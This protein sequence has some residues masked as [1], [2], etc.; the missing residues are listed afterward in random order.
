MKYGSTLFDLPKRNILISS[1]ISSMVT[2]L[3]ITMLF[4]LLKVFNLDIMKAHL[5]QN[6]VL[7]VM[8]IFIWGITFYISH[9][10]KKEMS[11][12]RASLR[13]HFVLFLLAHTVAL[14]YIVMQVNMS[15]IE[16][17]NWIYLYNMQFIL[18]FVV[19]YAIYIL[20]YNLIGKV[21]LSMILTSCTLVILGIVNYLK[22]I[23]RGD[24]LYPSDFT[25]IMH[26]Q[27][28]I[29]MVMDYFSW[30][31]IFVIILSIVAC[32]VAGIYMRRYIQNVKTHLGIRALLVVGS[33]FVLY[34]YGNFA[35]TFMN[36]VFQ[37]SGVDFVLWDQNENYASNGFVLG[38]ISNLDTTVMEK[39]K[40]YSKENML[41]I[42]NDIKKQY[43]GNIGSQKKKEKPNI[44]FVMSESFW[45]PTKATNLSF[46]EDPVPNLH[47]Y[48][49]NFPGGQTISPTFG[50]NTANVEFEALT[51]YS[52]S[53]LKPGSIPY[54]QVITNKKEIPSIPT[55]LKKE[56]YY[57]S[58]IHS[59]GRTFFKRDDVYKVLGFDKFNAADTMENVD[60]DGDYI[61]DLAM[62]KEIIAELEK[63]K[64]PTFIHAVTMQNHFPF[65]EGR[66]GENL[67]EISGLENEESKG[68]LETYT[69]GL[70]RSDEA[71]QYLIEQ[72]D[73]L[74]R[75]TL[76][77][78]F[79]DHLPSLGTNKSFYKENGYITNE[80][81]PSE[82]LAMAQ[83]PLLMYA[84][85]DMPNDNLGVVSPIYFSNLIFDYAGLNKSV[86]YQFLS[87]FYK[88]IPVLR[89]ELKVDKNGEVINDL[90]KKQK[91]MLEQYKILQYD[92]L[93]GNQY[94]KD[95]LFK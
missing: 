28:V 58:A 85:F 50:G 15:F 59:F 62:S 3:V 45:D 65:T 16:A 29:P 12:L 1:I 4:M 51:S 66:F 83:T 14:F 74:D 34:A 31:Y 19:I 71:L 37:K 42:A 24:P 43:S 56:G 44:I 77:V 30:S 26:M 76:L 41:Q 91:E 47:H 86:F 22:L 49:E 8:M 94:S 63:Q 21:F 6:L 54:Q 81:T 38:F 70:R 2:L 20:V 78:F 60:V 32:I 72:L 92:L 33:I 64:Q 87:A 75:P 39:P 36:K 46:S 10:N 53:L 80:K 90:T 40:N 79:G 69:E 35:N 57:T 5:N 84:N 61:S 55:A 13:V 93:V 67:I 18:S 73:N 17:M 25:Q 52:M 11:T 23:F 27:S 7:I 95:I 9:F 48:I 89:D 82:R 68:E 88:E